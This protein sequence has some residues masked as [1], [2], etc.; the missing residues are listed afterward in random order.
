LRNGGAGRIKSVH[1]PVIIRSD[2]PKLGAR[3]RERFKNEQLMLDKKGL[4]NDGACASGS[5]QPSTRDDQMNEKSN[6][7]AHPVM[8]ADVKC[9]ELRYLVI[10]QGQV[11]TS[12]L[13]GLF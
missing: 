5:S 4:G 12:R 8:L 6:K 2:A 10:R 9:L 3:F 1:R 11:G 13:A 7:V